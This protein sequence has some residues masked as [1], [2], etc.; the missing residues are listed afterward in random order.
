MKKITLLLLFSITLGYSQMPTSA[1]P[2]PPAR[3][4]TDVISIYGSVYSNI[5]GVNT[6]PNWG[7]STAVTEVSI[8]GNNALQYAN[9]NYQGTDWAGNVQNISGFEYLHVDVWTNSQAPNVFA[10]STGPEIPHAISSVPGSWQSLDIPVAGLT[11]N[12]NNVIQFKFDGGNGG[13][14][15][16]DNLYFWK[17]PPA[18][19]SDATLSDLKVAGTTV[20]GF[21][22]SATSYTYELVVGTTTVP[23]ITSATPND[24]AATSV[25]IN[26]APSIPGN[27]TVVVVSQN[28]NVTKTY[29][30][31]FVATLPNPSPTPS[32]PPSEVLSIYGDTGG[33]TNI[34]VPNYNFGS[35]EGYPDLDPSAAVN[36]AIKMNFATAGYGEGT[37]GVTDITAYNWLHFDYF[38]D[39][40]S[41][42]IRFIV[43]GNNG[44]VVEYPYELTTTGSNGTLIQG[45]WQSVNVPLSFFQ[46]SGFNKA[47]FFQYKLGTT[48]DLVSDIV[49]F[50]NIYF[51]AN[52][53]TILA[54]QNFNRDVVTAYPNPTQNEWNINLNQ[55]ITS[56]Q[57]FDLVGKKVNV[58]TN[59]D[60]SNVVINASELSNGIYFANIVTDKGTSVVKLIKN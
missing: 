44:G 12:S 52:P 49:Y 11:G 2:T 28:G 7:Q 40:N 53:G 48:S 32:T 60:G 50:D 23:Q 31:S 51:S 8:S 25:T 59:F 16:L 18:S 41:T 55:N 37:S 4:A 27:G 57:L 10:I 3:N 58:S 38:A 15:Y 34:W 36:Q 56:I 26:Q 6:N 1:A 14:I 39:S 9:F 5:S 24:P 19:G 45:S 29:T 46:G 30:V 20:P 33:F 17:T 22:S 21:N 35:N 42:Q 47:T 13:T 43:I 54:N